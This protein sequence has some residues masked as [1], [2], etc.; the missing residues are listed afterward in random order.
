[1]LVCSLLI[2]KEKGTLRVMVKKEEMHS[3]YHFSTINDSYSH[4]LNEND[5]T[6]TAKFYNVHELQAYMCLKH[7][8]IFLCRNIPISRA[9]M[10]YLV[11]YMLDRNV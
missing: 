2:G 10:R 8:N 4:L 9:A 6:Y 11:Y 3:L 1:M 7:L 5:H